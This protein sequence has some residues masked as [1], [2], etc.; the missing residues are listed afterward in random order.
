MSLKLIVNGRSGF[1]TSKNKDQYY[2]NDEETDFEIREAGDGRFVAFLNQKAYDV[3][4]L[5]AAQKHIRVKVGQQELEIDIKTKTDEILEKLGLDMTKTA[6]AT[7][8]KAPMPGAIIE[9]KVTAGQEVKKG[10]PIIILE[11]MKMENVIKSP[12][13]GIISQIL[14]EKGDSVEKNQ[15]LVHF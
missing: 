2:L 5:E 14:V 1:T 4:V 11:A 13:D 6:L 9:I 7:N 12:A 8:I 3:E 15:A 10:D